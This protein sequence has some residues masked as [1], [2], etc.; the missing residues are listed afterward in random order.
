MDAGNMTDNS[1]AI[2]DSSPPKPALKM[3][4]DAERRLRDQ[5]RRASRREPRRNRSTNGN[6]TEQVNGLRHTSRATRAARAANKQKRKEIMNK[7]KVVLTQ[8]QASAEGSQVEEWNIVNKLLETVSDKET[9]NQIKIELA[10]LD[11][12]N[13][14]T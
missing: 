11:E 1:S 8:N 9:K 14:F 3:N 7:G 13:E 10:R 4:R 6:V 5:Q 12:N 2:S